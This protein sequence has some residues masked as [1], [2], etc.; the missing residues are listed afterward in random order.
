MGSSPTTQP[1]RRGAYARALRTAQHQR[2]GALAPSRESIYSSTCLRR[3]VLVTATRAPN[4][5]SGFTETA[6]H[7]D[8]TL[9]R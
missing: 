5:L 9:T 6:R 4:H 7:E 2:D 3:S 8:L 1:V